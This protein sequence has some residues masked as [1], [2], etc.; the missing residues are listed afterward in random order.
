VIDVEGK[1]RVIRSIEFRYDAQTIRGKR[2]RV[3]VYGKN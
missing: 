1:D 3:F 2:A